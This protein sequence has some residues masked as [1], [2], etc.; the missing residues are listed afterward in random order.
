[1]F[2]ALNLKICRILRFTIRSYNLWFHLPSMILRR[3]L[4]LTTLPLVHWIFY[5]RD[6]CLFSNTCHDRCESDLTRHWIE[7]TPYRYTILPFFF[8][9][10]FS[11]QRLQAYTMTFPIHQNHNSVQLLKAETC[12]EPDSPCLT[13]CNFHLH[14]HAWHNNG[15]RKK[16]HNIKIENLHVP[17]V[18]ITE[19]INLNPSLFIS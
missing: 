4:I 7:A 8:F 10:S 15:H 19:N 11:G 5:D 6:T 18:Q 14:L 9:F 16:N 1:M 2:F 17:S 3:I 13:F 12:A